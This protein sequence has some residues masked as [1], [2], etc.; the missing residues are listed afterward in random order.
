MRI[1]DWSSDVCSSDLDAEEMQTGSPWQDLVET[2]D[3]GDQS[4]RA[5]DGTPAH[6]ADTNEPG[7]LSHVRERLG[8]TL[9]ITGM[10]SLN[11][12]HEGSIDP[13]IFGTQP[14]F[15]VGTEDRKST[16]LNSSH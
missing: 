5:M 12:R 3:D 11:D 10:T 8:A 15:D 6:T 14:A 9:I 13:G 4:I 7:T 1:S 2:I 16:R